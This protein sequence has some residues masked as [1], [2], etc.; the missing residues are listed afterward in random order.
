MIKEALYLYSSSFVGKMSL[1]R[2]VEQ[3]SITITYMLTC[4]RRWPLCLGVATD[5]VPV[6]NLEQGDGWSLVITP[7]VKVLW[8]PAVFWP[9]VQH[10]SHESLVTQKLIQVLLLFLLCSTPRVSQE[11]VDDRSRDITLSGFVCGNHNKW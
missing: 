1:A 8:I 2:Q 10:V 4:F 6:F 3:H 7:R 11:I 9:S 5:A